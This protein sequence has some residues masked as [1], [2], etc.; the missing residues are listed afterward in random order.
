M[1]PGRRW[2]S[3]LRCYALATYTHSRRTLRRLYMPILKLILPHCDAYLDIWPGA[4]DCRTSRSTTLARSATNSCIVLPAPCIIGNLRCTH[5]YVPLLI[6]VL[7]R[8]KYFRCTNDLIL[9]L[10]LH[11]CIFAIRY[12]SA[13]PVLG[14]FCWAAR[15]TQLVNSRVKRLF[16]LLT[17]FQA[18]A[19]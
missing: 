6:C 12:L 5:L 4:T 16:E 8:L 3:P 9:H 2:R 1:R 13:D 7:Q 17:C 10:I 15:M 14:D 11:L 18:F 19:A